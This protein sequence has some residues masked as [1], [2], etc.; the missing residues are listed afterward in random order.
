MVV[1]DAAVTGSACATGTVRPLELNTEA[2]L[3]SE[4]T[5]DHLWTIGALSRRGSCRQVDLAACHSPPC[6]SQA[7]AG[8][9]SRRPTQFSGWDTW[10]PS[11]LARRL[12]TSQITDPGSPGTGR[13]WRRT[14][15]H[16]AG[17]RLR[18]PRTPL[19]VP[20]LPA[21]LAA[22]PPRRTCSRPE[23]YVSAPSCCVSAGAR[24][25]GWCRRAEKGK[26]EQLTEQQKQCCRHAAPGRSA[27]CGERPDRFIG[28]Q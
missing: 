26:Q 10:Q 11:G 2:R 14:R 21:L 15:E 5:D 23:P 20:Q 16:S 1:P 13:R 28:I 22:P 27:R 8:G 9:S 18:S 17:V 19:P 6:P 24:R 7:E 3:A 12:V 25:A 4:C